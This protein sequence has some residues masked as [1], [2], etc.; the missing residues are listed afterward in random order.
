MISV[1]IVS[2]EKNWSKKIK[3]KDLFFRSICKSFPKKY[4]A[5][6]KNTGQ[7]LFNKDT[8]ALK[9]ISQVIKEMDESGE[10]GSERYNKAVALRDAL[11]RKLDLQGY[12]TGSQPTLKILSSNVPSVG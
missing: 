12:L 3:N 11:L 1:E 7:D 6:N 10:Q 9:N 8:V 5:L 4:S 2:E